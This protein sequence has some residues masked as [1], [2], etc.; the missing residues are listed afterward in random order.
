MNSR[1]KK[2]KRLRTQKELS[3]K[4]KI[5][6]KLFIIIGGVLLYLA[7]A[8]ISYA[9][10]HFLGGPST[11]LISPV[12]T[13]QGGDGFKIDPN[14]PKTEKCPLNGGM[15]SKAERQIWEKRRPLTVMIENHAEARPQSGLSRADVVYEAVAEGGITR[16]LAVF[17]CGAAEEITLGPVRSARTYFM[18]FASEYGDFPLYVHV[19]G[20]NKP[21][22]ANALGQI[23]D[24]G[25][26]AKGN[27]MN[28]FSI[29][30]PVFW[31][32]YE[33]I[34][35]PVATEHTMYSTTD[36]LW[37][38]AA[39]RGLN[40]VDDDGKKWD[41]NFTEWKFKDDEKSE[42]RGTVDKITFSFWENSPDYA[43]SLEYNKD[44]NQYLRFN[45]GQPHKDLDNDSQ[46]Q[47]K[48][49]I[50][51]FMKEKGPIDEIK[52]ILYGT[53]GTGKALIFQDGKAVEGTWTKE[54]RQ[55]RTK[56]TDK[57]GKEILLNRGPI[58]IEIVPTGRPV[59]Y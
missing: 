42:A 16:F 38:V 15:F 7:S 52:H 56:F 4:M 37:G 41:T 6:R 35:H 11:G 44:S 18:D 58:W 34:G 24:Y 20:A 45:D 43:V 39:K 26:L 57:S 31:R 10:F 14:A 33:R 21:G 40:A 50:I 46:I 36:K 55:S 59:N 3:K 29:G 19:G 47:A 1:P 2:N 12:T 5:N 48:T 54:K 22:P 9:A 51:Q 17:Y 53:T 32:D 28:Q 13:P 27:D 8:G 25:W 30:F 49:V 23:G